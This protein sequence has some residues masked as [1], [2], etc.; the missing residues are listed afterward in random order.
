MNEKENADA[1]LGSES[2]TSKIKYRIIN[3]AFKLG[4]IIFEHLILLG[5][6]KSAF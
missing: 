5:N 6:I 2:P 4:I 1:V 3:I